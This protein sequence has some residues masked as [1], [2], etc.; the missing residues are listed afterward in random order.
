MLFSHKSFEI[1]LFIHFKRR[2]KADVHES[3]LPHAASA[4]AALVGVTDEL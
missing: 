4:A 3:P 2:L 1:I